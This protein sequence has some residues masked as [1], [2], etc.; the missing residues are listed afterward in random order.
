VLLAFVAERAVGVVLEVLKMRGSIAGS[1]GLHELFALDAPQAESIRRRVGGP[2]FQ[3]IVD[4]EQVSLDGQTS[5]GE[6]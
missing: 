3:C 5:R 2:Q 4:T 1:M 6:R